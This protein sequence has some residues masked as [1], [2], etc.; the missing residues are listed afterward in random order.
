[1][2]ILATICIISLGVLVVSAIICMLSYLGCLSDKSQISDV[3]KKVV[4][5]CLIIAGIFAVLTTITAIILFAA[6]ILR[7][8]SE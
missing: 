8:V 6:D 4:K 3:C 2:E 1:M 7:G 5:I